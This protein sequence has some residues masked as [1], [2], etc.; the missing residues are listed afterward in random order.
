MTVALD[1][2]LHIFILLTF[3]TLFYVLYAAKM[4]RHALNQELKSTIHSKIPLSLQKIDKEHFAEPNR[5]FPSVQET[6]HTAIPALE[7]L[8]NVYAGPDK[9]TSTYNNILFGISGAVCAALFLII[10]AI[11]LTLYRS[12]KLN[13]HNIHFLDI[14]RENV[15]IFLIVG[16][17]EMV[18]F[19]KVATKWIPTPPSAMVKTLLKTLRDSLKT[20]SS[21]CDNN[22]NDNNDDNNNDGCP[23]LCR[24]VWPC[25][26]KKTSMVWKISVGVIVC[27]ALIGVW[28]YGSMKTRWLS[29][30]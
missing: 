21:R 7:R 9:A 8:K 30:A 29:S 24:D 3:L 6:L 16:A 13:H 12:C 11:T 2:L 19:T 28:L 1:S 26:N 18:F 10:L 5:E 4:E 27:L 15:F 23:E 17:V 25:V 14:I 20:T 22:N